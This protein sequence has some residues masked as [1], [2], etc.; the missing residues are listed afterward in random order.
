[1]ANL[2]IFHH[3]VAWAVRSAN[4]PEGLRCVLKRYYLDTVPQGEGLHAGID[5]DTAFRLE[6]F[7]GVVESPLQ[8]RRKTALDLDGDDPA[9]GQGQHQ[10]DLRACRR[11]I[12]ICLRS[13]RCRGA[14]RLK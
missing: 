7:A 9:T 10:I 8:F 5:D 2:S 4:I 12:E 1:M 6:I 3:T 11:A 13:F 14:E